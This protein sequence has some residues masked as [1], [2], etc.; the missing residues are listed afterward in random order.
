MSTT[1][2]SS[3]LLNKDQSFFDFLKKPTAAQK[4]FMIMAGLGLAAS[5]STQ[6]L[7]QRLAQAIGP[8]LSAMKQTRKED[9]NR[10]IATEKTKLAELGIDQKSLQLDQDFLKLQQTQNN[11]NRDYQYKLYK[12]AKDDAFKLKKFELNQYNAQP[13]TIKLNKAIDDA[14]KA[15]NYGLANQLSNE[16][17]T[18]QGFK[19]NAVEIANKRI[20]DLNFQIS[21]LDQSNPNYEE[22]KKRLDQQIQSQRNYIDKLTSTSAV[23]I[24]T[25]KDGNQEIT[26]GGTNKNQLRTDQKPNFADEL[27]SLNFSSQNITRLPS[28]MMDPAFEGATGRFAQFQASPGIEL[29]FPSDDERALYDRIERFSDIEALRVAPFFK[30]L[31]EKEWPRV[32]KMFDIDLG[33]PLQDGLRQ[34]FYDDIPLAMQTIQDRYQ[35]I[36]STQDKVGHIEGIQAR[37]ALAD[38]MITPFII[39]SDPNP[40]NAYK[41]SIPTN[42]IDGSLSTNDLNRFYPDVHES[43]LGQGYYTDGKKLLSKTLLEQLHQ[44]QMYSPY[45]ADGLIINGQRVTNVPFDKWLEITNYS[46]YK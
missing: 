37:M 24:R 32:R 5:S 41:I 16:L 46:E 43:A 42:S 40:R 14:I 25:D 18:L 28:I 44:K 23:T 15:E 30:P 6:A 26:Y 4:D 29:V 20:N 45:E 21:N 9:L 1:S 38:Q 27:A 34:K 33:I 3:G 39:G 11:A 31:S 19:P 8:G 22:N 10:K 13:E 36:Y 2:V 12:D 7:S 17:S 35:V